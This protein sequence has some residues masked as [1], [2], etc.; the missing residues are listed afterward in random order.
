[1]FSF[2][3]SHET[4]YLPASMVER[5]LADLENGEVV[6]LV[7]W[8]LQ[9]DKSGRLF[10]DSGLTFQKNPGGTVT[11]QVYRKHDKLYV[12]KPTIATEKYRLGSQITDT[13]IYVTLVG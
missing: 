2:A 9:A 5:T 1:M 4:D 7:P 13:S 6:W 10:M 8:S 11:M 3:S 12:N